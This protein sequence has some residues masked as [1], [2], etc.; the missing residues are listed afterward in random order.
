MII[1]RFVESR[2]K[3]EQTII[4]FF[5]SYFVRIK[6]MSIYLRDFSLQR[7]LSCWRFAP[8]RKITSLSSLLFWLGLSSKPEKCRVKDY[9]TF[10]VMRSVSDQKDFAEKTVTVKILQLRDFIFS[11]IIL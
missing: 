8:T 3:P 1:P 6:K 11:N 2:V 4:I 5:N 10:L 7:D 9:D